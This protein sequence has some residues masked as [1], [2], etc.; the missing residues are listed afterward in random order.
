VS[1]VHAAL[2]LTGGVIVVGQ[3][4]V[5]SM[6]NSDP[7]PDLPRIMLWAWESP[8]DLRFLKPGSAGIAFL[9]RTVWM[10]SG[11]VRSRP[12]L[13]P[14]R[15]PPGA[16]LVAVVRLESDGSAPPPAADV[17]REILPAARIEGVRGLQVDFDA[18][19]S[20][21]EWYAGCLRELKA[22]LPPYQYLTVTALESWCEE[23]KWVE[24]LPVADA[25]PMLFRLGPGERR[26]PSGFA[27]RLCRSS[28]GVS[29]DEFPARIPRARRLYFFHPGPWTR[30]AWDAAVAQA[31][32]WWK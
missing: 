17:V 31:G 29:T 10:E 20:Q 22:A 18:R 1:R 13:Q 27:A 28:V 19:L 30:E 9:A 14:L 21:R 23:G 11:A 12:R 5:W 32:R 7:T 26:E 24:T 8:Q 4:L 16:A 25:V 2:F 15:F 3:V 6:R